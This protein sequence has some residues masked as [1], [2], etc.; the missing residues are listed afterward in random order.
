MFLFALELF[1]ADQG[2]P[3][4]AEKGLPVLNFPSQPTF[5]LPDSHLFL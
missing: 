5:G 4:W 3:E 1:D 2:S